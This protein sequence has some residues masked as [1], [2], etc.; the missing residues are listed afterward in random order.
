M[1]VVVQKVVDGI[2]ETIDQLQP[3]HS[4]VDKTEDGLL[5]P[6]NLT[7]D[8]DVA[9]II[10][11]LVEHVVSMD[12]T[13]MQVVDNSEKLTRVSAN[14]SKGSSIMLGVS[15]TGRVMDPI[16]L[17]KNIFSSIGADDLVEYQ[18]PAD[19]NGDYYM[20]QEQLSTFLNVTS[21]KRKYPEIERRKLA[22]D[23]VN[24]LLSSHVISEVQVTLGLTAL[25]SSDV[26]DMMM[27]EYPEKYN[28]YAKVMEER[29]KRK[30]Q[31]KYKQYVSSANVQMEKCQMTHSVKK[32]IK[33]AALYNAHINRQR[34]EE[35][36]VY[37]DM[38]T[39]VLQHP[40][41]K[42]RKLD[43][44]LT[45]PSLY[46]CTLLPGQFQ[47]YYH[48]YTK[49][50]LMYFPLNTA[51]YG[52]PQPPPPL[53][54][55]EEKDS[56]GSESDSAVD[57]DTS[58]S[59]TP[60]SVKSVSSH[61]NKTSARSS[62]AGDITIVEDT[63][64]SVTSPMQ[65]KDVDET[66]EL[67]FCGICSND[68]SCNKK[69]QAEKFIKCSQCDNHGHPS[70]LEMIDELV[71]VILTYDWQC[72]ECKT[73][74]ICSQPHREDLMMFCDR[75]DRGYHTFCVSL[76]QIPSGVWACSRC[77]YADPSFVKRRRKQLRASHPPSSGRGR[78]G[79][80]RR[81]RAQN[82]QTVIVDLDDTSNQSSM[83]KMDEGPE[84]NK[85]HPTDDDSL[86]TI[87]PEQD[88]AEGKDEDACEKQMD[89]E[90]DIKEETLN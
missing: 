59:S 22:P 25:R 21:F 69:G 48:R 74:T 43:P 10:D 16:C 14:Q 32:A 17:Q 82:R 31:N 78:G 90:S 12:P 26:C 49:D 89:K 86:V 42:V 33:Q 79:K 76:R 73:C 80:R 44:E 87:K 65:R 60:P 75:C 8:N 9:K 7:V 41:R 39:N 28:E 51:L 61:K 20:L 85:N 19:T 71:S 88:L 34:K 29:E 36:A 24:H 70:C 11:D 55:L 68:E 64:L 62:T 56:S 5:L 67:P 66:P 77:T 27:R 15:Q 57:S 38:S 30:R 23:E 40:R 50:E 6:S 63:E 46:P 54:S 2:V 13:A 84:K 81:R 4:T 45:R 83:I 3:H 1:D 72:M 18:W 35:F 53:S 37:Y 52:P 58:V 47:E